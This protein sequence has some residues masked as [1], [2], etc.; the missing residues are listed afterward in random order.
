[1]AGLLGFEDES[2]ALVEVYAA[3]GGGAAELGFIDAAFEDV[4]VGFVGG[5]GGVGGREGQGVAEFGEEEREVGAL[6][7][8]FLALPSVNESFQS[9]GGLVRHNRMVCRDDGIPQEL[10][11]IVCGMGVFGR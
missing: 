6:L 8:A 5:A 3:G 10:R 1:L 2:A 7:P 9:V 11:R 4:V